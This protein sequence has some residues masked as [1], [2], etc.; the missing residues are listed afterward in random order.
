M[1]IIANSTLEIKYN[2][3]GLSL[4]YLTLPFL[5]I[6]DE[7]PPTTLEQLRANKSA[8]SVEELEADIKHMVGISGQLN[9][10][11]DNKNDEA[12]IPDTRGPMP[13]FTN[14][15]AN[16]ANNTNSQSQT[17]DMSAFKK[18]V[19]IL[20]GYFCLFYFISKSVQVKPL[21]SCMRKQFIIA[22]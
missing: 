13:Q 8:K 2:S 19:S 22:C 11:S 6:T 17:D 14:K 20:F 16:I 15:P 9:D 5:Q 12:L 18:F 1:Q 10:S 21:K 7:E 3:L 4:N